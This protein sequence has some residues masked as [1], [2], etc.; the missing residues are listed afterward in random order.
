ML[1]AASLPPSPAAPCCIRRLW[2]G[3]YGFRRRPEPSLRCVRPGGA[4][5]QRTGWR[6]ACPRGASAVGV[7]P[8]RRQPCLNVF[9][10]LL[11]RPSDALLAALTTEN[12]TQWYDAQEDFEGKSLEQG[13]RKAPKLVSKRRWSGVTTRAFRAR[14]FGGAPRRI[15][16]FLR[17]G[18]DALLLATPPP[19]LCWQLLAPPPRP[20]CSSPS[21]AA[22]TNLPPHT[23]LPPPKTKLLPVRQA[24]IRTA[25]TC[26]A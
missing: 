3:L 1:V 26:G 2:W 9:P 25:C 13:H 20:P 10:F 24:C 11:Q 21:S 19:V 7:H 15:N 6:V 18:C 8:Q 14:A 22:A 12:E 4:G 17:S 16:Y 23:S 5:S